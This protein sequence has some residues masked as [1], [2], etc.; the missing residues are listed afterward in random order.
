[1][2][3]IVLVSAL[4]SVVWLSSCSRYSTSFQK[5]TAPAYQ[6]Q[7]QVKTQALAPATIEEA[8]PVVTE[9]LTIATTPAL[10]PAI[11]EPAAMPATPP[12]P[13]MIASVSDKLVAQA[14]GTAYEKKAL[15]IQE[16]L[17]KIQE[18]AKSGTMQ[19]N[20]KASWTEKLMAKSVAKKI[21]KQLAKAQK[22]KKTQATNS[23][24]RVGLIL[25]LVGLLLALLVPNGAVQVVSLIMI[26][27]GAVLF[28][29]GL[30]DTI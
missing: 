30:V 13:E 19:A 8:K 22:A 16:K 10:A 7:A 28:I 27:L 20:H 12:T 9:E 4:G 6:H 21:Q 14:K 25:L 24:V 23:S 1:M 26:I 15:E 11:A 2:R 29:I 17:A 18:S 3:K 5:S